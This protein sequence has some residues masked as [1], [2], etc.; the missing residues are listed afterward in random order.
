MVAEATTEV[1]AAAA[2]AAR[3]VEEAER[4]LATAHAEATA[5]LEQARAT[6]QRAVEHADAIRRQADTEISAAR[7]HARDEIVQLLGSAR[8]E[9][10]RTDADAATLRERLGREATERYVSLL[11]EVEA[12]EHRRAALR[13]EVEPLPTPVA[14][15]QSARLDVHLRQLVDRLWWR[16][17]SEGLPQRSS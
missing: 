1:E 7:V 16:T 6:E 17:R 12:L 2:Q 13:A 10:R 5:R 15:P 8:D 3:I 11:T 14:G 4:T 9:R